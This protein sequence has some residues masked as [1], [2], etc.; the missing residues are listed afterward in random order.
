M[1]RGD[2]D[3]TDDGYGEP[4]PGGGRPSAAVVEMARAR[5]RTPATL[6]QALAVVVIVFFTMMGVLSAISPESIVDPQYDWIESFQQKQPPEQRQPLPPRAE[7]VKEQGVR[8]PIYA[9]LWLAAGVVMFI[10]GSKMKQLRGYGW[11]IAASIV[12]IFPGMCC[13]CVGLLPG[14]WG[15]AAL[16]NAD[17]KAAFRRTA[18]T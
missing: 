4:R 10:G 1:S 2:Y 14:I 8:G 15:L 7:A 13:C 18:V 9:V 11:S 12:A 17:V 3:D 6:L 16:L 5:V